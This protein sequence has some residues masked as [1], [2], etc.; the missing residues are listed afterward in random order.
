MEKDLLHQVSNIFE[1]HSYKLGNNFV[2]FEDSSTWTSIFEHLKILLANYSTNHLIVEEDLYAESLEIALSNKITTISSHKP[3]DKPI[4]GDIF[5]RPIEGI[6]KVHIKNLYPI[7]ISN[8]L[9]NGTLTTDKNAAKNVYLAIGANYH[10][11]KNSLSSDGKRVYSIFINYFFGK[12]KELSIKPTKSAD[13]AGSGKQAV[14][15]HTNSFLYDLADRL[16]ACYIKSNQI[17][18]FN[19]DS[20]EC[21]I[22]HICTKFGYDYEIVDVDLFLYGE[23]NQLIEMIDGKVT[24]MTHGF[25]YNRYEHNRLLKKL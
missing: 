9:A 16:D 8:L 4:G 21:E 15:L 3:F 22:N 12:I 5:G 6:S 24:S 10:K 17:Y 18:F 14:F 25:P 19:E 23:R 11:I 20:Y 7:T 1:Q 13:R 2:Y